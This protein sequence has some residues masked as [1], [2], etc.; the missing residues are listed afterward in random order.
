MLTGW[1]VP[2][3]PGPDHRW[4][5]LSGVIMI[6]AGAQNLLNVKEKTVNEIYIPV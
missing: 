5:P 3:G 6:E 1:V 2:T 4:W